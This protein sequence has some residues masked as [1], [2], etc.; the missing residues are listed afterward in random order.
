MAKGYVYILINEYMPGIVKIG[1]TTRTVEQRAF[2]LFQTGVPAPFEIA[3]AV[4]SPD[5]DY[6]EQ[7]IHGILEKYRISNSREFFRL[8]PVPA[9]C[10]LDN[11]LIDQVSNW[12]GE[13]L[14]S[15]SIIEDGFSLCPSIPAIMA[16]HVGLSAGD[17]VDAYAYMMPEEIRPAIARMAAHLSGSEKMEWLRPK[18]DDAV[19]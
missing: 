9:M 17:V 16:T 6:L 8:D 3:K 14:P 2:E 7:Q 13:F 10:E 18:D 1:K 5:C 11:L 4:L 15:H 19:Y 12:M